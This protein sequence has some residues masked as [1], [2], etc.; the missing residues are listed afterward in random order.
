MDD[1]G[2]FEPNMPQLYGQPMYHYTSESAVIGILNRD[3][4][5]L[6]LKNADYF[7]D[8]TEGKEI[9]RHLHT[10]CNKLYKAGKITLEQYQ[11]IISLKDT[12]TYPL[13]YPTMLF[14]SESGGYI[15]GH[16]KCTAYVMSFCKEPNNRYMWKG[17]AKQECC[18]HFNRDRL[19]QWF[20]RNIECFK[21]IREVTYCDTDK[22]NEI[23]ELILN[24]IAHDDYLQEIK[25][26][27]NASRYFYKKW[28]PFH[29]EKEIRLLF[30]IPQRAKETTYIEQEF[31]GSPSIKVEIGPD[32]EQ[33]T[34]NGV[35]IA[36]NASY[37]RVEQHFQATDHPL[38][39]IH[40]KE[41]S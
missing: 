16:N 23:K 17:Y 35:T 37:E 25:D 30:A 41:G 3:K 1:S 2:K 40:R 7:D 15:Q 27:I 24:S 22:V 4:I 8:T 28:F 11:Q 14:D 6:W 31:H 20:P 12:E 32:D 9:Y 26:G 21:E 33:F 10:A 36:K 29:K 18:L 39:R 5:T 13:E 38:V 34:I 19:N